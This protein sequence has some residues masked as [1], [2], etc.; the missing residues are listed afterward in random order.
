MPRACNC[1][2]S[3]CNKLRL[4]MIASHLK[5]YVQEIEQFR[6]EFTSPSGRQYP[7]RLVMS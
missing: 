2:R 7:P 3:Q 4:I 1:V 5:L 6:N